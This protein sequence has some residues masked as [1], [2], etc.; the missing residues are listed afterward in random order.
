[1]IICCLLNSPPIRH[2]RAEIIHHAK[3]HERSKY[4]RKMFIAANVIVYL[5]DFTLLVRRNNQVLTCSV[6]CSLTRSYVKGFRSSGIGKTL[7]RRTTAAIAAVGCNWSQFLFGRVG[8]GGTRLSGVWLEIVLSAEKQSNQ[9]TRTNV[10]VER[11]NLWS[12]DSAVDLIAWQVGSVTA[13][14]ATSF[15]LRPLMKIV[16]L[17]LP[18]E[19]IDLESK[20]QFLLV[21][22]IVG[23]V[24][25]ALLV[26]YVLHKL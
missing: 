5:L 2:G 23:E 17:L 14:C 26:L 1:M 13:I 4:M 9:F 24:A 8:A 22:Y 18:K 10:K 16:M 20:W 19:V 3:H 25:P 15:T 12:Y 7:F 6:L 11:G 21:Y